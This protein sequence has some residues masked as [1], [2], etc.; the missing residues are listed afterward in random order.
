MSV[1]L[2]Y[3]SILLIFALDLTQVSAIPRLESGENDLESNFISDFE[4]ES[5][6]EQELSFPKIDP[7]IAEDVRLET[8]IEFN[9]LQIQKCFY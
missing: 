2:S 6:F 3:I 5:L 9:I 8:V 1:I 4:S 7:R